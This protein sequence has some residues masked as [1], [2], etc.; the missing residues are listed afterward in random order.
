MILGLIALKKRRYYRISLTSSHGMSVS[1][2]CYRRI[3]AN[4]L[5]NG[6]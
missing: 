2:S 3:D 1:R 5:W 4:N 6:L